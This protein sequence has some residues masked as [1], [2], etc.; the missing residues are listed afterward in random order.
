MPTSTDILRYT[1]A[2]CKRQK[3]LDFLND[4]DPAT[5]RI[6]SEAT[7]IPHINLLNILRKM[8]AAKEV[9]KSDRT[10]MS[11]WLALVKTTRS[12]LSLMES[13]HARS[14]TFAKQSRENLVLKDAPYRYIDGHL[15]HKVRNDARPIQ[16]QGGQGGDTFPRMT[17]CMG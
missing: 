5:A 16:H 3:V 2:A 14:T 6:I 8:A 12:G 4:R 1:L 11:P 10:L 15:V 9:K 13:A 17:S 7:G